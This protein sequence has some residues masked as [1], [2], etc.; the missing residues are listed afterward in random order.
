MPTQVFQPETAGIND[1]ADKCTVSQLF[2]F[3]FW[4]HSFQTPKQLA[5]HPTSGAII[6]CPHV[7]QPRD[8]LVLRSL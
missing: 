2:P 8:Y 6:H 1:D 3:V 7:P 4:H 5:N